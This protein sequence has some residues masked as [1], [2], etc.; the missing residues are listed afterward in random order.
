MPVDL[1]LTY[2]VVSFLLTITP[3]A[4][5]A[6]VISAGLRERSA[7]PS[8]L[9]L[10]IGYAGLTA[11][12][13]A[14]LAVLVSQTPWAM[15]GLSV[16]GGVYLIWLGVGTIRNPT[17]PTEGNA[18]LSTSVRKRLMAG[19]GVSGLNPKALLLFVA[20]LPQFTTTTAEWPLWVQLSVL[21][22]VHMLNTF[23]IYALVG[24]FAG[25]VLRARPATAV[26]VS[27]ISGVSMLLIGLV[28]LIEKF[29]HL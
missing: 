12:V 6:F 20:L 27:R 10:L 22:V 9:G 23:I 1:I 13:A 26:L 21:G 17:V 8:I 14:G 15:L 7:V 2:W 19:A 18:G 4:D 25:R 3:G 24:Y 16:A 28:L 11:V 5:W 29:L